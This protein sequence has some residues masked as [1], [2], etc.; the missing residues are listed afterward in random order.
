MFRDRTKTPLATLRRDWE[1]DL[2]RMWDAI[3]KPPQYE[4]FSFNEFFDV[5]YADLPNYEERSE[6]FQ[7]EAVLLRRRFTAGGWWAAR[8]K[9]SGARSSA[10][11]LFQICSSPRVFPRRNPQPPRPRAPPSPR[12]PRRDVPA[13]E[14]GEA[15]GA[16]AGDQHGRGVGIDPGA[17]GS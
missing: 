13:R 14:R 2:A 1:A 7:A 11:A 10:L 16:R 4:A 15:A 3:A 12:R 9:R 6:D 17:Q 8:G 5:Q